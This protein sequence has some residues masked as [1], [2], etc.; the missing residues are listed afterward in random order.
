MRKFREQTTE[1]LTRYWCSCLSS[2]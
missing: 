2:V 1:C